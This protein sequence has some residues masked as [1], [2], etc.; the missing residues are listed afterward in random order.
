M[1][2]FNNLSIARLNSLPSKLHVYSTACKIRSM[3]LREQSKHLSIISADEIL[4]GI[5]FAF[6]AT[7]IFAISSLFAEILLAI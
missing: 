5:N 1:S 6:F 7:T 4:H 2:I 3:L